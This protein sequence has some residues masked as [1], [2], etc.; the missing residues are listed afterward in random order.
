LTYV[1]A[2]DSPPAFGQWYQG[3]TP[4]ARH[5]ERVNAGSL[6]AGAA[7]GARVGSRQGIRRGTAVMVTRWSPSSS[8]VTTATTTAATTT[9]GTTTTA[10]TLPALGSGPAGA[11]RPARHSSSKRAVGE[12]DPGPFGAPQP[13]STPHRSPVLDPVTPLMCPMGML[14]RL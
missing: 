8:Y 13:T 2:P 5:T 6:G 4:G 11:M 10:T 3:D 1:L 12:T 9:T 7:G 14:F